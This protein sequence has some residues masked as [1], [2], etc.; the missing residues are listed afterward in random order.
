MGNRSGSN[1][2]LFVR[3]LTSGPLL[4]RPIGPA[5]R[6]SP[7]GPRLSRD[8]S[9]PRTAGANERGGLYPDSPRGFKRPRSFDR[10]PEPGGSRTRSLGEQTLR[11]FGHVLGGETEV[12]RQILIGRGG[13]E[14]IH[15]H[16]PPRV[17]VALPAER[18]WPPRWPGARP[19]SAAAPSRGTPRAGARTAPTTAGSPPAPRCPRPRAA[20]GP[21]SASA[22][23]EPV[24]IRIARG[25]PRRVSSSDVA[26]ASTPARAAPPRSRRATGSFWRVSASAVGP[27]RLLD[28]DPPG[29]DRLVGVGRA[30]H[31]QVRDRAQRRRAGSTGW[32]VGPSS[33]RKIES[34]VKT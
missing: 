11:D 33:P 15:R 20:A 32:C 21:S 24:A 30:E 26:A 23:S 31:D 27:V 17:P 19:G 25:A 8:A 18:D 12:S 6:T 3:N 2:R 28:R 14:P 16:R 5:W 29:L 4:V 1:F 34:W 13:A 9:P 10:R 22:T 7:A